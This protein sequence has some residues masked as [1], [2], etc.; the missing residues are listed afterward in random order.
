[1]KGRHGMLRRLLTT[2]CALV[3]LTA[4]GSTRAEVDVLDGQPSIR[5]KHLYLEGR[6]SIAVLFGSTVNDEYIHNLAGGLTYRYFLESWLGL[7][8]DISGGFGADTELTGQINAQLSP[9]AQTFTL[10]TTTLRLLLNASAE[11][12]PFEGKFMIFGGEARIDF[13][14]TLGF[15]M[16][17]VAGSGRI[18]D[19][20]SIMPVAGI[21]FRFFPS[22]WIAI[23][24]DA[25]D[26]IVER[27]LASSRD[28]SIP[29]AEFGNNWLLS[30]S[31]A[32]FFPTEPEIR[33]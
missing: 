30:L 3:L 8:L 10:S 9:G 33:P 6:H 32:F 20:I 28:G 19:A 31:I 23:G 24:F 18:E 2:G 14:I 13:H 21:G 11:I 5:N 25:R 12:V 16:A 27:V 17:L 26:Y 22:E 7:G 15:G 29:G 1:M 4:S